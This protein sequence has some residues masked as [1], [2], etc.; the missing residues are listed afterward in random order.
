[1]SAIQAAW[2]FYNNER[3]D[4][5]ELFENIKDESKEIIKKIDSSG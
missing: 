2:R 1:M 5:Q 4:A 3:V